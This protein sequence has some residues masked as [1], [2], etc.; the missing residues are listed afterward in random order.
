MSTAGGVESLGGGELFCD[1]CLD[2]VETGSV[3]VWRIKNEI[4]KS[5]LHLQGL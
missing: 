2:C 3:V 1:R 4:P 5:N